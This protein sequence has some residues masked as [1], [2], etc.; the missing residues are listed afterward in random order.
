LPAAAI[1]RSDLCP[2]LLQ[3]ADLGWGLVHTPGLLHGHRRPPRPA[4]RAPRSGRGP[5]G[6]RGPGSAPPPPPIVPPTHPI[7]YQRV[8][9]RELLYSAASSERTVRAPRPQAAAR[10]AE[11]A[12]RAPRQDA[13][14]ARGAGGGR[15]AAARRRRPASELRRAASPGPTSREP[16]PALGGVR[17]RRRGRELRRAL[18]DWGGARPACTRPGQP[19]RKD[20]LV[21]SAAI[22]ST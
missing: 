6:G 5:A 13:P 15:A 19:R 4:P 2:L 3:S 11:R 10:G 18:V 17:A 16:R 9:G 22:S 21:A 1:L 7:S 12:A 14:A 20:V 8:R